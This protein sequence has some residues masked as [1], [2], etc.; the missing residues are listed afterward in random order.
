MYH[1]TSLGRFTLGDWISDDAAS[2][3]PLN[4]STMTAVMTTTTVTDDTI[5]DNGSG[6]TVPLVCVNCLELQ[7]IFFDSNRHICQTWR[8]NRASRISQILL[9]LPL[10]LVTLSIIDNTSCFTRSFMEVC[11][12]SGESG[13]SDRSCELRLTSSF[14]RPRRSQA[15]SW[16]SRW[17]DGER[18]PGFIRMLF[19]RVI[20]GRAAMDEWVFRE[21]TPDKA[22]G[23]TG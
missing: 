4:R 17:I 10:T 6:F 23:K 12:C 13:V 8:T 5:S 15:C 16:R 3:F 21:C 18:G 7:G 2:E 1:N 20:V 22:T 14:S 11:S 19:M 9:F